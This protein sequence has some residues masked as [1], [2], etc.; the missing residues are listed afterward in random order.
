MSGEHALQEWCAPDLSSLRIEPCCGGPKYGNYSV[1]NVWVGDGPLEFYT[2]L[3]R[4]GRPILNAVHQRWKQ[5]CLELAGEEGRALEAVFEDLDAGIAAEMRKVP[6]VPFNGV[7]RLLY[8][9][10]KETHLFCEVSQS[11]KFDDLITQ[12]RHEIDDMCTGPAVAK[13][14]LKNLAHKSGV[15]YESRCILAIEGLS[16]Q[17]RAVNLVMRG[18]DQMGYVFPNYF[19][20]RL[21]D[22][23]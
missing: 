16:A 18:L 21:Y 22:L 12:R 19:Y 2:P 6:P 7:R 1:Y 15:L 20:A 5:A 13:I 11:C 23:L 17:R 10:D 14:R 3:L 9:G 8:H 4:V